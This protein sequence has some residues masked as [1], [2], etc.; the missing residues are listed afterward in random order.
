MYVM[1]YCFLTAKS[2]LGRSDH[3]FDLIQIISKEKQDFNVPETC[4]VSITN[5]LR[6]YEGSTVFLCWNVFWMIIS[7]YILVCN[8]TYNLC[9]YLDTQNITWSMILLFSE[10][11]IQTMPLMSA[12]K[13]MKNVFYNIFFH[14]FGWNRQ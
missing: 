12:G 4:T 3:L 11:N 6:I 5:L 10:I 14:I 13:W 7:S 1:S 8:N 2:L 9:K